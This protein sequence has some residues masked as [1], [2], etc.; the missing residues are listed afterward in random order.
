MFSTTF[1]GGQSGA[2]ARDLTLGQLIRHPG[3]NAQSSTSSGSV[4]DTDRIWAGTPRGKYFLFSA[5]P[6]GIY[7]SRAQVTTTSGPMTDIVGSANNPAGPQVIERYD[8][9]VVSGGS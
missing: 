7:F 1:A 9:V 8:D 3:L 2:I 6:D 5:G 4:S